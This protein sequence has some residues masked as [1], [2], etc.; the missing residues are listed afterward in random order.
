MIDAY[1]SDQQI[2][3]FQIQFAAIFQGLQ[4]KTGKGAD[5]TISTINVP[6]HMGAKDR[7]V[8]ALTAG[9]THNS[10]FS[11]PI[12]SCDMSAIDLAPERRKGIGMIDRQVTM[13]PGGIYPN[14]L[15]VVRR[16]MPVPYNMAMELSIYASNTQQIHQ[17]L[18]QIL[19]IF[20]PSVQIQTTDANFDWT[21]ITMV[22]LTGIQN[23]QNY[24]SGLD[25]RM[26]MWTLSFHMP[27]WLSAPADL[28]SD[29]VKD[30]FIRLGTL[31]ANGITEIDEEGNQ[32]LFLD[33]NH[34]TIHID[35]DSLLSPYVEDDE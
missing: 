31:K 3:K 1:Y 34:G 7:V 30:I 14:D 20:D 8:A 25:R 21:K 22:E 2:R 10:V 29:L 18:E 33:A 16:L 9:N 15:Q 17:I 19:V 24:P 11:L 5:G 4:V 26:I 12:M 27:I 6:I 13:K 32:T 35:G 28:K 23:E